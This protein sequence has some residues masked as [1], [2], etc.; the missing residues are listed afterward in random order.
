MS[1]FV[2]ARR[3]AQWL[4]VVTSSCRPRL[5]TVVARITQ[6]HNTGTIIDGT[7]STTTSATSSSWFPLTSTPRLRFFS[8]TIS[9]SSLSSLHVPLDVDAAIDDSNL[10]SGLD[11]DSSLLLANSNDDE[12]DEDD[13][14]NEEEE[15][16]T[17][18]RYFANLEHL[19]HKTLNTLTQQGITRMTDIQ[20]RTYDAVLQGK[21]VV[22]RSRT[23]SGKAGNR[24]IT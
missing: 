8:T 7:C 21:D 13:D 18:T 16:D 12:D 22:G 2:S 19:H 5:A 24:T 10:D 14:D 1:A 20:A 11:L 3:S 15:E 6:T 17:T 9:S 4:V 23:G